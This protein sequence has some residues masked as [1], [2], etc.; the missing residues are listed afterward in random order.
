MNSNRALQ[1][2]QI[3][4]KPLIL[5]IKYL[6]IVSP[7]LTLKILLLIIERPIRF[8]MPERERHIFSICQESNAYIKS[9]DKNIHLYHLPNEGPK[10]L[11]VHGWSGRGTQFHDI[12]K[13]FYELGYD[14]LLFDAPAHGK[15]KSNRTI[16]P[17]FI[18]C[19]KSLHSNYGPFDY[20]IGH[21]FGSAALFN[22][23]RLGTPFK[24]LITISS[25]YDLKN[26]FIDFVQTF[27]LPMDYVD[28]ILFHYKDKFNLDFSDYNLPGF[29]HEVKLP[30]LIIHCINDQ[31]VSVSA[32]ESL[33]NRLQNAFLLKTTQLGHRR[34]LRDHSV[35]AEII[36]FFTS[37]KS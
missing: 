7:Y 2:A 21:S 25:Q 11:M 9:I 17:E 22:A 30:V 32:A 3:L 37:V 6:N 34:I 29:I 27:Q 26:I 28:K 33:K 36:S 10:I 31:D 18:D 8:R 4:P 35:I 19:I 12:A 23:V 20:A 5:F 14:V 15:S 13:Q 24:K 16:L 1:S